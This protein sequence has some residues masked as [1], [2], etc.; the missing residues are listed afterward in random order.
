M[1]LAHEDVQSA[2]G[3]EGNPR[4]E[5]QAFGCGNAN[6]EPCVGTGSLAHAYGIQILDSQSFLVQDFLNGRGGEGGVHAGFPADAE[7]RHDA[8][9]REGGG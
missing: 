4:A 3:K 5:A 9:L 6:T 7:G 8:V 2:G 1:R